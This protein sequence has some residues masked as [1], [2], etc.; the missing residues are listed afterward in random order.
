ML[1]ANELLS[2]QIPRIAQRAERMVLRVLVAAGRADEDGSDDDEIRLAASGDPARARRPAADAHRGPRVAPVPRGRTDRAAARRLRR[3]GGPADPGVRRQPGRCRDRRQPGLP[4]PAPEPE[5][6]RGGAPAGAACPDPARLEVS[7]RVGSRTG[8]PSRSPARSPAAS[9][10]RAT[11]GWWRWRWPAARSGNARAAI[12]AYALYGEA[13][14]SPV[15]AMLLSR[16]RRAARAALAA[17]R[18]AAALVG[19]HA[20]T[21][22]YRP[23][24][25]DFPPKRR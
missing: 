8:T 1:R 20:L 11:P 24:F 23:A 12:D 19:E 16:Q 2:T 15:E 10:T 7:R 25:S 4:A 13:L 14:R 22:A 17:V 21:A 18:M 6:A 3:G 5:P 9:A